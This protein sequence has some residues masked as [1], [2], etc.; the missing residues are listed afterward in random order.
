MGQAIG[1]NLYYSD[2][3]HLDVS[4]FA[5]L[6][7]PHLYLD[8]ACAHLESGSAFKNSQ[9]QK[10]SS[11]SMFAQPPAQRDTGCAVLLPE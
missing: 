6:C 5:K 8:A 7:L 3:E 10:V 1:R 2:V 9:R 4:H 11:Y